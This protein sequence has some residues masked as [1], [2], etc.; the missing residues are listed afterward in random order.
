MLEEVMKLQN[1]DP[2]SISALGRI[3]SK[4]ARKDWKERQMENTKPRLGR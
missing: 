3:G 2:A 1:S 4:K